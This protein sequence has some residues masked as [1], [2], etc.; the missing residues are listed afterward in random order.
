MSGLRVLLAVI[1][2]VLVIVGAGAVRLLIA[3]WTSRT[4]K[5][6][7]LRARLGTAPKAP[8]EWESRASLISKQLDELRRDKVDRDEYG[9]IV[10]ILALQNALLRQVLQFVDIQ[11]RK[12]S[13]R[14]G[15]CSWIADFI[16]GTLAGLLASAVYRM[17]AGP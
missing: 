3:H 11:Q 10:A 8:S 7:A 16:V 4:E 6:R 17:L 5:P 1:A 2:G 13:K 12:R 15:R 14:S 9:R